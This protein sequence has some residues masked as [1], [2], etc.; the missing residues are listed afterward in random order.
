MK[1]RNSKYLRPYCRNCKIA[2]SLIKTIGSKNCSKCGKELKL[3]S[4]NPW[5]SVILGIIILIAGLATL[6][7]EEIPVIW[8][9]GF[10][11]GAIMLIDGFLKWGS[12]K[13]LDQEIFLKKRRISSRLGRV[14]VRI[15]SLNFIRKNKMEIICKHCGHK[16]YI[17]RGGGLVKKK[18]WGCSLD[19]TIQT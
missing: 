6:I 17:K 19:F 1:W 4:F 16:N 18:C 14:L 2:Y 15:I 8:I 5:I 9:G 10:L 11:W 13:E 3:K 12:I 7:T